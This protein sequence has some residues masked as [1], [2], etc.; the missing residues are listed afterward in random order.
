MIFAAVLIALHLSCLEV[1]RFRTNAELQRQR[2]TRFAL[3]LLLRERDD[4]PAF[5]LLLRQLPASEA[6]TRPFLERAVYYD[7]PE[8]ARYLIER[9]YPS[10]GRNRDGAPLQ[11]AV[12]ADHPKLATLLLNY[13]AQPDYKSREG[14]AA[15]HWAAAF[16][17][18]MFVRL[19]LDRGASI[20][21][22]A[23]RLPPD[24]S[25]DSGFLG[26]RGVPFPE[27]PLTVQ[28]AKRFPRK[29]ADF[30]EQGMT[31]LMF[32]AGYGHRD[33]VKLLLARGADRNAVTASGRTA[34]GFAEKY[35]FRE[36]VS[37]MQQP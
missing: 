1:L 14:R 23:D 20:N 15:L 28:E 37:L 10:D 30:T 19:L 34:R 17:K 27:P 25:I 9:G 18:T 11:L 29:A 7:R 26:V 33:A 22:P 32:A 6:Q 8:T 16:G 3:S 2:E 35:G 5:D 4:P 24:E 21:L 36:I 13:K 31:P 12:L